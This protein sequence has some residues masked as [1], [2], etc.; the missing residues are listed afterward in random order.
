MPAS[1]KKGGGYGRVVCVPFRV[2]TSLAF[3]NTNNADTFME[4]DMSVANCGARAV[5]IA[6]S[7][8]KFRFKSLNAY[9]YTT[10]NS[11]DGSNGQVSG[12][13][14]LA[15]DETNSVDT[16]SATT[17]TQMSQYQIVKFGNCY[18]ELKISVPPRVLT[19][20]NN[21][22]WYNTGSTGVPA[23]SL[24]PG[25]FILAAE[26]ILSA[27]T[28]ATNMVVVIEGVLEFCIEIT[29]ALSFKNAPVKP[30]VEKKGGV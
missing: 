24:A 22:V 3:S 26:N 12:H 29:P 23:D 17:L 16:G 11:P 9:A 4:Y 27:T 13:F 8:E 20:K 10:V 30:L 15:Y 21:Y 7:F 5:A 28:T 6:S 25:M 14:A 19:G 18:K 2:L 1:K